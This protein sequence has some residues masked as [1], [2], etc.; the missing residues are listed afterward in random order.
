MFYCDFTRS[1]TKILQYF[2]KQTLE[3]D[4]TPIYIQSLSRLY[5]VDWY[6]NMN[7]RTMTWKNQGMVRLTLKF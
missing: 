1:I 4:V 7:D 3:S 2:E 5:L 6:V